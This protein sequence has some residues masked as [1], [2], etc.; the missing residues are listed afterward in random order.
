MIQPVISRSTL[1]RRRRT[2]WLALTMTVVM[3]T[4]GQLCWKFAAGQ[5]PDTISLWQSFVSILHEPLFHVAL[6][7]YFLQFFNWMIVLAHADLSYAQPITALSY[8]TVSGAS[9]AMFHEHLSLLRVLGLVM[10][11]VGVWVISRT[12]L[13]TAGVFTVRGEEQFQPEVPR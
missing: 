12:N 2:V 6:L 13:R 7:V 3:D 8:V 9:M 11:L 10:I 5:V 4:I 1:L